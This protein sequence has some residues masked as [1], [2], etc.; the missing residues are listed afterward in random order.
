[1]EN[2]EVKK[3]VKLDLYL[4]TLSYIKRFKSVRGIY[5]DK[6]KGITKQRL[7]YYLQKLK[8]RNLIKKI[9]YGV[10]DI[11]EVGR[12]EVKKFSLGMKKPIDIHALAI[13][14]PIL[15]DNKNFQWDEEIKKRNWIAKY[16]YNVG[17]IRLTLEKTTKNIIIY[18]HSRRLRNLTDATGLTIKALIYTNHYLRENGFKIDLFSPK[19]NNNHLAIKDEEIE[20]NVPKQLSMRLS[21]NRK[22][23]KVFKG[24]KDRV[25]RV[26]TDTS[27]F[28]GIETN[29]FEYAE[30]YLRMP[31]RLKNVEL[32][33]IRFSDSLA[34]YDKNIRKHLAI[35][36]LIG[37]SMVEMNRTM[38]DIRNSIRSSNGSREGDKK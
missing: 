4:Y 23:K 5:Q 7:N 34:L 19:I 33:L 10:W 1:M 30:N 9:G 17:K 15:K 28:R 11:T 6:S 14:V 26:W 13:E 36:D 12:Q 18:V 27:P 2:K 31:E 8:H 38:R 3:E 21:L 16:K 22:A 20:K 35:M 29:D 37:E 24:D 25:A 32:G